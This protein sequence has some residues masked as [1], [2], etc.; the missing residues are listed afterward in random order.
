MDGHGAH[1]PTAI[2][3]PMGSTDQDAAR[4]EFHRQGFARVSATDTIR[5]MSSELQP[6][7]SVT[8]PDPDGSGRIA[9]TYLGREEDDDKFDASLHSPRG[10]HYVRFEEGDHEGESGLFP[11]SDIR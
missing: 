5:A 7:Q 9:A 4:G 2:L 1:D 3:A 11:H 10:W 8:V 6:G